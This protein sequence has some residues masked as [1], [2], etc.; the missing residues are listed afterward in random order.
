MGVFFFNFQAVSKSTI[1]L[2]YENVIPEQ[3]TVYDFMSKLRSEGK[4]NFTEKNYVGMGKFIETINGVR[5]N[6]K[7]SWI[8]YVNDKKAETGVSNYKINKGDIV[9][10]KYEKNY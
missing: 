7:E 4:M 6:G 5:G 3:T 2:R 9:S 8:Y 10:W 1:E